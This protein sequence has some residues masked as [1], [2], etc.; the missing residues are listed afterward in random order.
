[1]VIRIPTRIRIMLI[2][3]SR[4]SEER[5]INEEDNTPPPLMKAS[6]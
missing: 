4:I 2:P 6:E 1:M 5:F 3:R